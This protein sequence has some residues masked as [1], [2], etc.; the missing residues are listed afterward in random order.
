[1]KNLFLTLAFF[2]T[3]NLCCVGQIDTHVLEFNVGKSTK[4]EVIKILQQKYSP[5][6]VPSYFDNG[7]NIN[8]FKRIKLWGGEWGAITFS[9]KKK[10]IVS[11]VFFTF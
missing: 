7:D 6:N 2:L 3:I 1:M 4:N 11:C 8:V 10:H 5:N 9:F